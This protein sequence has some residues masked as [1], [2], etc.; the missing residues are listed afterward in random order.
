MENMAFLTGSVAYGKPTEK[1]D[2]DLVL[3]MSKLDAED[4]L[5]Y[6]DKG[7]TAP[8]SI[9]ENTLWT[10]MRFGKLNLIICFDVRMYDTW[11]NG[12]K[13]LVKRS[14]TGSVTRDD[15]V[16]VFQGLRKKLA[17]EIEKEEKIND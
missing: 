1:S 14:W 3:L 4:L 7:D 10:Q 13:T 8:Y 16:K 2:V 15:A 9:G 11:K 5:E 6:A 12:T 17:E